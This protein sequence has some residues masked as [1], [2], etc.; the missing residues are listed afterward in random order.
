MLKL[1][2]RLLASGTGDAKVNAFE[3]FVC[4]RGTYEGGRDEER[5]SDEAIRIERVDTDVKAIVIVAFELVEK[6]DVETLKKRC[7]GNERRWCLIEGK[8]GESTR[9]Y[10]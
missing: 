7:S 10:L 1:V 4:I 3:L 9:I 6:I 8:R 2:T 5:A